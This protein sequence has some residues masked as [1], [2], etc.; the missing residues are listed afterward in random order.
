[1][2]KGALISIGVLMVLVSLGGAWAQNKEKEERMIVSEGRQVSIEYSLYLEDGTLVDSNVGEEPFV[3]TQGAHQIIPGLESRLEGLKVGDE[4]K[5][6]VPP[7]EGYGPIDMNAFK[8]VDKDK[9]PPDALKVGTMLEARD[10][11]GN[12]IPVRIHEI[13]EDTVIIDFNHPLAG[14][15][16]IF[17][18]KIL[19]VE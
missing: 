9:I 19:K 17:D 5:I 6:V 8:E 11:E 13:K 3:Y 10:E 15:N 12:S 2:R 4:K 18:V 7:E 1:M 14:K 16:L